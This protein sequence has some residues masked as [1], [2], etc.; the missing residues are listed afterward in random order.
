MELTK[1]QME[2]EISNS[3]IR[4]EK[5]HM[6]RG[7]TEAKTYI[8]DDM[9][10]VRLKNVLTPAEHQLAR[11]QEGK[12]LIKQMRI[13][14]FENSRSILEDLILKVTGCSVVSIHSDIS[15]VT[16][17]RVIVFILSKKLKELYSGNR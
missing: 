13:Q 12:G 1:G 17:E 14:L 15:T 10:V 4:F 2:A 16:G 3:I 5:E 8:L 6:G 7:P 11:T 9:I